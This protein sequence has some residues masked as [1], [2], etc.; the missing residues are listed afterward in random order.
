MTDKPSKLELWIIEQDAYS[1]AL[2]MTPEQIVDR[3][4]QLGRTLHMSQGKS[5]MMRQFAEENN[6]PIL[7][8]GI[9]KSTR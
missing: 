4:I 7:E 3:I 2:S 5:E 6:L 8:I 9:T 1:E